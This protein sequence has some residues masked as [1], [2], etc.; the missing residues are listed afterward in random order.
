MHIQRLNMENFRAA[1]SLELTLHKDINV[2]VGVNGAGKTTCLDATAILLSWLTNRIKN[3]A[4]SGQQILESDIQ[5][6]ASHAFIG[7]SLVD[8]QTEYGWTL[9][10]TKKGRAKTASYLIDTKEYASHIQEQ[11]ENTQENTNIPLFVYYPIN[12]VVHDIPLRIRKDHTF[13]IIDAYDNALTSGA[14]FRTFFEWFRMREDLENESFRPFY[15]SEII[16]IGKSLRVKNL[17]TDTQLQT[18]RN[19]L[20][21][22]M[23][24]FSE[25]HIQRNPLRMVVMKE[26]KEVYVN[27]L[28]DGEKC[29]LALIG[30]LARRLAIANPKRENPLH[31]EG[32]IL[33]D[34]IDLHLHPKWQRMIIPNLLE[35]FPNCQFLISTHSPH[36]LTHV[37]AEKVF[38]LDID[39]D[40]MKYEN[41]R[42]LYGK[43]SER[44]L[45]D[46]MGLETTRPDEI[47]D[48][49]NA[50]FTQIQEKKLK[51]AGRNIKKLQEEIGDDPDLTKARVLIKRMEII[52]K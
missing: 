7:L 33:I 49:L 48:D 14:N 32:V 50:I 40:G 23:P 51:E 17:P 27:Q 10:K 26:G 39:E 13:D 16:L 34:E 20:E 43:T 36:V 19:A 31:G 47:N 52:G 8:Y 41:P 11:I 3:I 12:R 35:T 4:A 1:T 25:L 21:I 18:V 2:F 15:H 29:L 30:D 6:T 5:N 45:E 44:I 28:S 38:M 9:G 37:Q 46:Y 42:H 22:F 24:D